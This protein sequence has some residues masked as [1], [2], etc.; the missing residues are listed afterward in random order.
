MSTPEL[1]LVIP[2]FNEEESL[3]ALLARLGALLHALSPAEV[4]VIFVDDHSRD[5]SPELLRVACAEQRQFRYLRLSTNSGSHIAIFAG[6]EHARGSCAAFLAADLQDPPE[7]LARMLE[8]WR[9]GNHVVWAVRE[10]R[11]GI[12]AS[13]RFFARLFYFLLNK[14]ARVQLPPQGSDF[15]LIDRAALDALRRSVVGKP[16][17][18]G[19]IAAL[20]FRQTQVGYVKQVRRHGQT[21]WTLRRKL[22]LMADAFVNFS[23]VPLRVMSYFGLLCSLLGFAYAGLIILLRVAVGT[24]IQGWSSLM[25]AV[26]LLGGVQMV[27][28]GVLGEYLWRTLEAAQRRP[29]YFLEDSCPDDLAGAPRAVESATLLPGGIDPPGAPPQPGGPPRQRASGGAHVR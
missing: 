3:P 14:I 4:E 19:E 2:V 6:L 13:D 27:M 7:L 18:M 25:V 10:Q 12:P 16:F 24:P 26:L 5:R 29:H 8:L 22:R 1:S 20:G 28:L 23:Y 9:A 21:K 15:V 11:E 17:L